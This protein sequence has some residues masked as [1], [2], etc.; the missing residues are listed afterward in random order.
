VV[1]ERVDAETRAILADLRA[2]SDIRVLAG[3]LPE[4]R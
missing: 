4:S 2:R 3:T 1:D